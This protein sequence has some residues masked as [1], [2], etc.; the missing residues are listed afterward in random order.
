MIADT[1]IPIES[2][3]EL[4]FMMFD[5]NIVKVCFMGEIIHINELPFYGLPIP[6]EPIDYL[7]RTRIPFYSIDV[8]TDYIQLD[9]FKSSDVYD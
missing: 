5:Y 9:L 7:N 1:V 8:T 3:E 2:I 6:G 4:C